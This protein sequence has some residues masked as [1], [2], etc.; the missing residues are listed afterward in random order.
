MGRKG[1]EV[2]DWFDAVVCC[3]HF[4]H[5]PHPRRIQTLAPLHAMS[6]DRLARAAER[7]RGLFE[8][9][10]R[11][12]VMLVVG[13]D[14]AQHVLDPTVAKRMGEEVG[15]LA[16]AAGGYVFAITSP[17]TAPLAID[18]LEASLGNRG[19]V[20]RWSCGEAENPYAGYLALADVLIVTG[21]S[22]SMLAE[23]AATDAPLYIYPLPERARGFRARIRSWIA[24][25]A[26][27]ASDAGRSGPPR[28]LS[29]AVASRLIASGIVRT[30]RDLTLL[31][32]G[33]VAAG[34]ARPFGGALE[35][36]R[37]LPLDEAAQVAARIRTL[38]EL[39]APAGEARAAAVAG[40][41]RP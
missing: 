32:Q 34:V 28:Q 24:A 19:Q 30:S 35:T 39:P 14:T 21:E 15:A 2:P 10:P 41:A 29:A 7:W 37:R 11:P 38:I 40:V 16:R 12:H 5:S 20:R 9:A 4:G 18:A 17:R 27:R 36:G 1:G 3:A 13:G 26:S 22:E 6:A 8:R 31:H 23:A 33:L 25:M